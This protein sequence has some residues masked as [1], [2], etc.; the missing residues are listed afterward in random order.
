MWKSA[1]FLIQKLKADK[2]V[3]TDLRYAIVLIINLG[4]REIQSWM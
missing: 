2:Y 4:E 3:A 1:A